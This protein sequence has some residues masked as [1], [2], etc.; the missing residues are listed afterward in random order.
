MLIQLLTSDFAIRPLSRPIFFAIP[1][2]RIEIDRLAAVSLFPRRLNELPVLLIMRHQGL[3]NLAHSADQVSRRVVPGQLLA[4]SGSRWAPTAAHT[5]LNMMQVD[6]MTMVVGHMPTSH[7]WSVARRP[8]VNYLL[9][10]ITEDFFLHE[11]EHF[12]FVLRML[13]S[14]DRGCSDCRHARQLVHQ[15][16]RASLVPWRIVEAPVRSS[17]LV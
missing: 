6:A 4:N 7:A 5:I 16:L 10:T 1:F 13:L 11:V 12:V 17:L 3:I 8:N 15:R 14:D 9:V 2:L